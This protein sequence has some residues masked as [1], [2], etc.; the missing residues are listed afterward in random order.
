MMFF[1][2][3]NSIVVFEIFIMFLGAS[4]ILVLLTYPNFIKSIK[5]YYAYLTTN[6]WATHHHF[7]SNYYNKKVGH[8]IDNGYGGTKWD[9][10][11]LIRTLPLVCVFY[12]FSLYIVLFL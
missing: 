7:H 2:F 11:F 9:I 3:P 4:I 1:L 8:T 5:G 12:L 6:V 10:I